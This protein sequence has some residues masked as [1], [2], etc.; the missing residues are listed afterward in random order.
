MPGFVNVLPGSY[1]YYTQW[2][3]KE[4]DPGFGGNDSVTFVQDKG[5]II[6]GNITYAL[7]ADG[8]Q[9][10]M[11]VPFS[12]STAQILHGAPTVTYSLPSGPKAA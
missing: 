3:Y 1:D 12:P 7:S 4:N 6:T 10:E 5:P 8:H 9:L 2:V 11:M